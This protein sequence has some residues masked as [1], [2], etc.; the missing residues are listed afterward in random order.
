MNARWGVFTFGLF[1]TLNFCKL[2]L[3][4]G[5]RFDWTFYFPDFLLSE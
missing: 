2:F 3:L 4:N 1:Q 5:L